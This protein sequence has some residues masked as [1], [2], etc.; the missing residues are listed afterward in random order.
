MID[1]VFLIVQIHANYF[2]HLIQKGVTNIYAIII[3]S[4]MSI[5]SNYYVI[6]SCTKSCRC[7][8]K[9]HVHVQMNFFSI[10]IICS[11]LPKT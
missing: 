3:L 5:S 7:T 11:V 10:A 9:K 2:L 4:N 1:F 6:N 8:T